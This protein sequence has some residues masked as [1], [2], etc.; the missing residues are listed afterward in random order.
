MVDKVINHWRDIC[1]YGCHLTD[2]PLLCQN[3]G[4]KHLTRKWDIR[5]SSSL[6]CAVSWYQSSHTGHRLQKE[7]TRMF[8]SQESQKSEIMDSLVR[9][10]DLVIPYFVKKSEHHSVAH[11]YIQ[12]Y[13]VIII[14]KQVP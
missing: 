14:V 7:F 6:S 2:K 3:S 10:L 4:L 8:S 12:L 13:Y 1:H 11:K 5:K 9:S